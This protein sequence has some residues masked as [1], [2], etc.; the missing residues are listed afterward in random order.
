[1][2][3]KAEMGSSRKA[4]IRSGISFDKFPNEQ[5]QND[6]S[7]NGRQKNTF[8]GMAKKHNRK[9]KVIQR[10]LAYGGS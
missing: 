9:E 8:D 3:M 1:M 4:M 10:S 7:S 6:T 5:K 2:D